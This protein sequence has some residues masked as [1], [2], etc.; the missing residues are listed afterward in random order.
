MSTRLHALQVFF[1]SSCINRV[2]TAVAQL[3]RQAAASVVLYSLYLHGYRRLPLTE[4]KRFLNRKRL[5]RSDPVTAER[6]ESICCANSF[7]AE[8][9]DEIRPK[10]RPHPH[11][12]PHPME[13]YREPSGKGYKV[14]TR[15]S[16]P[17]KISNWSKVNRSTHGRTVPADYQDFGV[18]TICTKSDQLHPTKRAAGSSR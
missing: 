9:S 17:C 2:Q 8:I 12:H 13:G 4:Q 3:S 15:P 6:T 16:V 10:A 1:T 7:Q 18:Q 14:F 5:F 11:P